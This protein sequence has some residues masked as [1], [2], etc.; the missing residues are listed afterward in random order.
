MEKLL[1]NGDG[2]RFLDI[3]DSEVCQGHPAAAAAAA[4]EGLSVP[5]RA[6]PTV[7][8]L[9]VLLAAPPEQSRAIARIAAAETRDVTNLRQALTALAAAKTAEGG[10]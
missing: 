10:E 1:K 5:D 3:T 7:Y 8:A 4:L 9:P 6:L 2:F